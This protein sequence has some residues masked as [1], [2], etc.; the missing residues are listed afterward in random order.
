MVI[1]K[2]IPNVGIVIYAEKNFQSDYRYNA[3]KPEVKDKIAEMTLNGSGAK[4]IS[5]NLRIA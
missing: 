1:T 3:R 2:T 4:D 5:S